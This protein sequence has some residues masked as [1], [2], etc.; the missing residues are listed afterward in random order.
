MNILPNKPW[1]KLLAN[2][3]DK[4][5]I[6]LYNQ[7]EELYEGQIK[8][9]GQIYQ[10]SPGDAWIK[11]L[12]ASSIKIND[13]WLEVNEEK[14]ISSG[15]KVSFNKDKNKN[16]ESFDYVFILMTSH[17]KD[18][19]KRER[20]EVPEPTAMTKLV[21]IGNELQQKLTCSICLEILHNC[22]ALRPCEHSFCSFCLIS[23]FKTSTKCPNC[24]IDA[25][26]VR[27]N[28]DLENLLELTLNNFPEKK[29]SKEDIEY[30]QNKLE[31]NIL[32]TNRGIY[33]G[34]LKG[35][36][37]EG[38]GSFIY[39][40]GDLFEGTW[41]NNK[42]EGQGTLASQ[43]GYTYK[44]QWSNDAQ[45]IDEIIIPKR[46]VYKGETKEFRQHGK[47]IFKF[48]NGSIYNGNFV[49]GKFEGFGRLTY[50]E[51][52]EYEGNWFKGNKE[53][54]G[55]M[56]YSDRTI[57]EGIWLQGALQFV[58]KIYYASGDIYE[59]EVQIETV[60]VTKQGKGVLTYKNGDRFEGFWENDKQHGIG[61]EMG[62]ESMRDSGK[63]EK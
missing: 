16:D 29:R 43:N 53:G 1:A 3:P 13:N 56:K 32:K 44:G 9:G 25:K 30:K 27:K 42:K 26:S 48:V 35:G 15:E 37:L 50:I 52:D 20:E 11:N 61:R 60:N 17:S 33:A 19:N 31:G 46:G 36:V 59:G 4:E 18:P 5:S 51:G 47:G 62:K 22:A 41:Q 63:K 12:S 54:Y 28:L 6:L 55:T 39:S 14:E 57:Y 49:Q 21:K 24:R 23:H 8:T 34:S 58:K 7:L 45:N 40:N 10:K 38:K 2:N